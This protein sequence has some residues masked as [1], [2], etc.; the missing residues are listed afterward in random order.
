MAKSLTWLLQVLQDAGLK[1]APV[2]GWEDRGDGDVDKTV[3]VICHHTAGPRNGNMPSLQTLLD[4]RSDLPGP[5]AQLGLGRDGTFYVIAAGRCNH[6]GKGIWQGVTTGNSSFIGIEAENTGLSDDAPWPDVQMDAYRRGVAA[7]LKHIGKPADFCAGHKEY[8]L[9]AGRKTD[10]DFDM[11]AFRAGV[12]A[13]LG[14]TAPA[15]SLIPAVEPPAEP[16]APAGRTTLRRSSTGDLVKQ[17]QAK[18]GVIPDGNFGP[19]TEAAVRAFQ[20]AHSLVP[21]GIVGP[22]TW[23]ALDAVPTPV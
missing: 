1:V 16:G 4:G 6:A 14:G 15:P 7:I 11:V 8:A 12:A 19:K 22:K 17:V 23:T 20:Q 5:L 9:P 21:D 3:G 2:N 13:I 10:P 18:V